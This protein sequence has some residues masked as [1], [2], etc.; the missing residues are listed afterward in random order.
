M[1]YA[2]PLQQVLPAR[3]T[4][5]LRQ[6]FIAPTF[7]GSPGWISLLNPFLPTTPRSR[8]FFFRA[9]PCRLSFP[10]TNGNFSNRLAT[11]SSRRSS[12]KIPEETSPTT[13]P[14]N[15]TLLGSYWSFFPERLGG[16][17]T[18]GQQMRV[19]L[20]ARKCS[21]RLR[22]VYLETRYQLCNLL[23]ICCIVNNMSGIF[24]NYYNRNFYIII[25]AK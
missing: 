24:W 22:L 16:D 1:P 19:I 18:D 7:S 10:L 9:L 5:G 25:G 13:L 15:R 21:P 20:H 14:L 12:V 6:E 11:K 3:D 2:S 23:R 17:L 8:R 4:A